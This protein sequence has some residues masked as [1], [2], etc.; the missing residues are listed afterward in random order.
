MGLIV[1]PGFTMKDVTEHL[2]VE[3]GLER[4]QMGPVPENVPENGV[5][6]GEFLEVGLKLEEQQ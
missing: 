3:D 1:F 6:P 2:A 5:L 4:N